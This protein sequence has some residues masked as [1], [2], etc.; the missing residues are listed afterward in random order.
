MIKSKRMMC[1]FM[2]IIFSFFVLQ[3]TISTNAAPRK[4]TTLK[5]KVTATAKKHVKA[6][7]VVNTTTYSDVKTIAKFKAGPKV[8]IKLKKPKPIKAPTKEELL[9]SA[10][11][12][13]IIAEARTNPNTHD[14]ANNKYDLA[15]AQKAITAALEAVIKLDKNSADYLSLMARIDAANASILKSTDNIICPTDPLGTSMNNNP[16]P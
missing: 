14:F 13:V 10:I 8:G 11:A 3:N 6:K 9:N 2:G 5:T 16:A 12:A 1:I 15:G 4:T 7:P